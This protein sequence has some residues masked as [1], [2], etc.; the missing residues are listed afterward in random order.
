MSRLQ[1]TGLVA[2]THTPFHDDGSL[3]LAVVDRQAEHLLRNKV[4]TVFI[5]GSTGESHSLNV[6]ERQQLTTRWMEVVRG[7]PLK[8]VVHVGSNCLTD[9]AML[10]RHAEKSGAVAVAALSPSYFK[11][12][13]VETLVACAWQVASA[14]P[15]TPFYFYDI[16]VLT[17]VSLSMPE[18]LAHGRELIPNLAGLKFTNPDLM[19]YQACL[20]AGDGAFDV[21]WGCDE[22]LLAALAF[23][24]TGAVGSTYNFA[25]PIFHRVLA[26]FAA[27]D[28]KSARDEQYRAVQMIQVLV[29]YG[30]IGA[31]KAVMVML[32]VDVGP[33][34]LPNA[35]LTPEQTAGLRSDLETLGFFDWL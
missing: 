1:L 28:L 2:A 22:I 20:R 31:T 10:A 21:P 3:N 5:G 14:A 6:E 33:A 23:G 15:Q 29:R 26:A 19:A 34:R 25:A 27:G 30:F 35:L 24:A 12:R 8:V 9:A 18:F 7:T 13:N 4:A 17:G 16:P 32:G 11:P